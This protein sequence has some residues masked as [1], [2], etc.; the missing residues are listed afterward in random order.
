MLQTLDAVIEEPLQQ[1]TG[2]S[3][4]FSLET[5]ESTDESLVGQLNLHVRYDHVFGV[6]EASILNA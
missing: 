1:E 3:R 6:R 4:V 5:N 2:E